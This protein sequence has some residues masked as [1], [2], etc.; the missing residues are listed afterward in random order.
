MLGSAAR[1]AEHEQRGPQE[2]TQ[3]VIARRPSQS[4]VPARSRFLAMRDLLSCLEVIFDLPDLEAVQRHGV[5]S[6][7]FEPCRQLAQQRRIGLRQSW[8]S[9]A[10][11]VQVDLSFLLSWAECLYVHVSPER[12]CSVALQAAFASFLKAC[13]QE[14]FDMTVQNEKDWCSNCLKCRKTC[15]R[16]LRDAMPRE[17]L[18]DATFTLGGLSFSGAW[19]LLR[20]DGAL[21]PPPGLMLQLLEHPLD[22][23]LLARLDVA[24]LREHPHIAEAH[25]GLIRLVPGLKSDAVLVRRL[26]A[27]HPCIVEELS[28][29]MRCD[30]GVVA[31]LARMRAQCLLLHDPV[32]WP[33]ARLLADVAGALA[34]RQ[35]F[36]SRQRRVMLC[37]SEMLAG[38]QR[39]LLEVAKQ[40]EK[41]L[42]LLGDPRRRSLALPAADRAPS[43]VS[44]RPK[45]L[46]SPAPQPSAP[47]SPALGGALGCENSAPPPA[48]ASSVEA[49]VRAA[50]EAAR[51]A[52]LACSRRPRLARRAGRRAKGKPMRS[53]EEEEEERGEAAPPPP[54]ASKPSQKSSTPTPLLLSSAPLE[55]ADEGP[56]AQ[57]LKAQAE[58]RRQ[59]QE[60]ARALRSASRAQVAEVFGLA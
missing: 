48:E 1:E 37:L 8:S 41:L 13:L 56:R 52:K 51:A 25:P 7:A 49:A 30:A 42:E 43:A 54:T 12:V 10:A 36:N 19:H 21:S 53:G 14:A 34:E 3:L 60:R 55:V 24:L 31:A 20:P 27:R 28:V 26:A 6:L 35:N 5:A 44:P 58:R 11:E 39:R 33:I 18:Q 50:N 15:G 22:E 32:G 29:W 47:P 45:A 46:P 9:I 59:K 57:R 2:I 38:K 4:I 17:L 16:F 40:S 23:S